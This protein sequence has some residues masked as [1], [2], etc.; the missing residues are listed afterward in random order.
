VRETVMSAAFI[1]KGDFGASATVR[2]PRICNSVTPE[3]VCRSKF[4]LKRLTAVLSSAYT[5][6]TTT[7]FLD[8]LSPLRVG[9]D[10]RAHGLI[11]LFR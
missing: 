11:G 8:S 5:A 9:G 1:S 7:C 10:L 3:S 2:L 6:A 4:R